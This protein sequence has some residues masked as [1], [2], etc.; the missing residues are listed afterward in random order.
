[1][2]VPLI[3]TW[4]VPRATAAAELQFSGASANR[5][6]YFA[7]CPVPSFA[8][9]NESVTELSVAPATAR[10]VTVPG[11]VTAG[12]GGGGGGGGG[13]VPPQGGRVATVGSSPHIN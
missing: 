7:G 11:S 4:H 3:G 12:G 1:M 10:S 13:S 2:T 6:S 9:V 5:T 8:S